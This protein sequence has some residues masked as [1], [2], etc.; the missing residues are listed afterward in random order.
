MVLPYKPPKTKSFNDSELLFW[1][2]YGITESLLKLYDVYSVDEFYGWKQQ[3]SSDPKEYVIKGTQQKPIFTYQFKGYAKAYLPF[4]NKMRFVYSG[5]KPSDYVF[6]MG[7]L[8]KKGDIVFIAAGEKDVLTLSSQGFSAVCF[9]SESSIIPEHIIEK[10]S[11]RFKH[12]VLVYDMDKTG[13]REARKHCEALKEY[14]LINLVIP[15]SGKKEEKDISDYFKIGYSA[16]DLRKIF[17]DHLQEHY[18]QT[19][20]LLGSFELDYNVAPPAQEPIVSISDVPIG[21]KGNLLAITGPEGSGKSNFL[22]ALLAGTLSPSY[23]VIDTLGT[24][25]APNANGEAV[26]YY[27]TEQSDEQLFKNTQRV[28]R[29][30]ERKRIPNWFKTYGLV[31]MQRNDRLKSILRSMDHFYYQF[32]GIH[33][34]VIDGIADLLTGVNDEDSSVKL[35]D[36][37]FRLAA[38]YNCCIVIVLHLSPSGYKLRGHLGSEI[39]RKAAGIISIE[40]DQNPQFSVIKALKVRTGSPMQVPQMLFEWDDEKRMHVL[41]GEKP[42]TRFSQETMEKIIEVAHSLFENNSQLLYR[43]FVNGLSDKRGV[44]IST[45]EKY[46]KALRDTG[47]ITA[48]QGEKGVYRLTN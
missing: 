43:K 7:Q 11:F 16:E 34:V 17:L 21:T 18:A 42:K 31:G 28:F 10:L 45:A 29:R 1:N 46:V 47:V 15:L 40:K 14:E 13:R 35:V 26:L 6:G 22:G 9:N 2:Q 32:G 4:S 23:K 12:I 48:C 44:S 8:P 27:D 39:Q 24:D 36:E 20:S 38:I 19:M 37:I 33:M 3:N 25:V 41:Y 30:V 5:N